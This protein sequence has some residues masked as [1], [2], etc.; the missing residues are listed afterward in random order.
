MRDEQLVH[1]DSRDANNTHRHRFLSTITSQLGISALS[2]KTMPPIMIMPGSPNSSIV[3]CPIILASV[4]TLFSRF[5]HCYSNLLRHIR[6]YLTSVCSARNRYKFA[7]GLDDG[8]RNIG[9]PEI[10]SL[11]RVIPL[12]RLLILRSH[13]SNELAK[14]RHHLFV[15]V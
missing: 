15:H 12:K 5:H 6:Q 14:L 9:M 13:L 4:E 10:G 8:D 7:H 2:T 1:Q 11:N 3:P